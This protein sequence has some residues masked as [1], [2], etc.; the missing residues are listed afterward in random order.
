MNKLFITLLLLPIIYSTNKTDCKG[1]FI[2]A[3]EGYCS[4]LRN[5]KKVFI[6]SLE[7]CVSGTCS[8]SSFEIKS[9]CE[10][11][12]IPGFCFN[13]IDDQINKTITSEKMCLQE[14]GTWTLNFCEV[15]DFNNAM[16]KTIKNKFNNETYDKSKHFTKENC[17]LFGMTW[18]TDEAE[19][20]C[21]FESDGVGEISNQYLCLA[22][23]ANWNYNKK[24]CLK[25][26]ILIVVK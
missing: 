2:Q 20:Y 19:P 25:I 8:E 23:G 22:V 14:K 6:T 9:S 7:D 21:S 24:I 10:T 11:K 16:Y 12:W 3:T 4:N 13:K 17:N 1:K 18:E 15:Y 5:E 26:W